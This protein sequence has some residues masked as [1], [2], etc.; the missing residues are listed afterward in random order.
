MSEIVNDRDVLLQA[1]PVRDAGSAAAPAF[2]LVATPSLF[3]VDAGGLPSQPTITIAA[4]LVNIEGIVTW[5]VTGAHGLTVANDTRSAMLTYDDVTADEVHVQA[6]VTYRGVT[7]YAS[8][9]ILKVAQ[10][11]PGAKSAQVYAYKRAAVL[12]TDDPGDVIY[13]FAAKAITTPASNALANG[14]SK[15]I[16]EGAGPLY[17]R[18]GT[19]YGSSDTDAIASAEWAAA[20]KLAQDG[21]AGLNSATVT[22]YQRSGSATAPALPTVSTTYTFA[23][24]VLT[25]LNNGWSTVLPASGGAYLH[26]STATA[27]ATTATDAIPAAEWAAARLMAQDGAPGSPGVGTTGPRGTVTVSVPGYSAWPG[28]VSAANAAFATTGYGSPVNRDTMTLYSSTF[29]ETR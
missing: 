19:A 8:A 6:A 15:T 27:A 28:T 3:L 17:V 16:P 24:G 29:G 2:F 1:A 14:W 4:Q 21:L 18:V 13:T 23:T 12:P 11:Q 25:G 20:A 9:F 22:I 5:E 26:A 7:R 10:G